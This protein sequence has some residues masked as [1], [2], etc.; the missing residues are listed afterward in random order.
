MEKVLL[1]ACCAVCSAY[2]IK[3]L[4]ENEYKPVVYFYNPNIFPRQ[5]YEIR[6]NEIINYSIK[7]N[8]ELIVEDYKPQDFANVSKGYEQEPEKGLRCDRCFLLRLDKTAQKAKELGIQNFTTT[9][10]ISPHKISKNIFNAGY[11]AAKHYERVF[12]PYDF[13]KNDGYKITRQIANDNNMYKQSYCG[14][15]YSIRVENK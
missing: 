10:S 5:E 15:K 3:H 11:Q 8:F 4:Y 12:L 7:E 2:C 13:K 6:L 1:H 14:C 9:L